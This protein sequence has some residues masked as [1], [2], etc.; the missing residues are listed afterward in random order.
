MK[1]NLITW[2]RLDHPPGWII[3]GPD[4]GKGAEDQLMALFIEKLPQYCHKIMTVIVIAS[5][6]H[7]IDQI[8]DMVWIIMI[9]QAI[10]TFFVSA[11]IL[12]IVYQLVTRPLGIIAKYAQSTDLN[13]L[14]IPLTIHGKHVMPLKRNELDHVVKAINDMRERLLEP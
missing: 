8:Y 3:N 11:F 7:V 14:S 12:Y 6:E 5:K 13:Q 10:K 9:S 1:K 4:S 2:L